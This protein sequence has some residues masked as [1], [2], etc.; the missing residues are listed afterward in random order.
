MLYVKFSSIPNFTANP[1]RQ[2]PALKSKILENHGNNEAI[3]NGTSI[4]KTP[5]K[6]TLTNIHQD[7]FRYCPN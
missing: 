1:Q 3:K 7:L 2:L 5:N 4:Q 6:S